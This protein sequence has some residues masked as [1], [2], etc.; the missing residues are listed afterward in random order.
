MII[1][2]VDVD[3]HP[4]ALAGEPI[5]CMQVTMAVRTG[6]MGIKWPLRLVENYLNSKAGSSPSR[7]HAN[8]SNKAKRLRCGGRALECAVEGKSGDFFCAINRERRGE[9]FV[10]GR[11]VE[12]VFEV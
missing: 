9:T 2:C 12:K 7:T 3:C 5:A 6:P 8:R 10:G 4:R 1:N 11:W